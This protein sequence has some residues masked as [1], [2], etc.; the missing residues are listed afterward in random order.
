MSFVLVVF[1]NAFWGQKIHSNGRLNDA[2][3]MVLYFLYCFNEINSAN[4]QQILAD[5]ARYCCIA[6]IKSVCW[7]T[8]YY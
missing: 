4:G 3:I 8:H 7:C 1:F 6:G 5:V 2:F